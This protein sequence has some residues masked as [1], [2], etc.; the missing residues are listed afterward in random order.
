MIKYNCQ[1]FI[2]RVG[3]A[4]V[5][6]LVPACGTTQPSHFYMLNST[7][8]NNKGQPASGQTVKLRIGLGPVSLPKYLDRSPIV[9]RGTGTEVIIDDL[10][11]WAEPLEDN[12]IRVLAENLYTELGGAQISLHPWRNW[13]DIAYQIVIT[14]YRF[15]SDTTGKVTLSSNWSIVDATDEQTLYAQKSVINESAVSSDYPAVVNAQSKATQQLS[16]EIAGKLKEF[17]AQGN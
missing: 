11:R 9:L 5:C 8:D 1:P 15:D 10:H 3:I 12:F 2:L 7:A 6:F 16:R 13:K 17:V 14:V 4:A